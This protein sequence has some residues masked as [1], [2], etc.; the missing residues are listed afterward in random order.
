MSHTVFLNFTENQECCISLEKPSHVTYGVYE[1]YLN[2][3]ALHLLI[4]LSQVTNGV[5]D[6]CLNSGVLHLSKKPSH[7]TNVVVQFY[8]NLGAL[9]L[10]KKK[11]VTCHI[12]S[13]GILL[14]F[15]SIASL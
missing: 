7:V 14:K 13:F 6:I 15:R 8:L 12:W 2:S 3:G 9:Q 11:L 4:K 5:L 1:F 10:F